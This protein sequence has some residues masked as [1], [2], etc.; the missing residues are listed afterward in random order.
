M[1]KFDVNSEVDAMAE[2][3]RK[4]VMPRMLGNGTP[5][6]PVASRYG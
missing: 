6:T 3:Q 5:R 2:R 1:N 4:E